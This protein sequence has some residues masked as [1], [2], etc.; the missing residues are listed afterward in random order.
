MLLVPDYVVS[1]PATRVLKLMSN[2]RSNNPTRPASVASVQTSTT[3]INDFE[4][5]VDNLQSEIRAT[6]ITTSQKQRISALTGG[7]GGRGGHGGGRRG[8]G[9][10][11]YQVKWPY[12]GGQRGHGG[13]GGRYSL[14]KR[15]QFNNQGNPP[16]GID[17]AEDKL[18]EPGCYAKFT[19]EQKTRLHKIR[20]SRSANP[21]VN[22]KLASV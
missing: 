13:P 18:Y 6:K 5:T 21:P 17:W 22:Q 16:Q 1:N 2:I 7:R 10:N 14:D 3:L 4:K 19:A 12:K 11:H 8:V 20:N 9:G 15:V